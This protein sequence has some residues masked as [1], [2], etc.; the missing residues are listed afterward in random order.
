MGG[1]GSMVGFWGIREGG[2]TKDEICEE[3]EG[4]EM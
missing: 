3:R 4:K 1:N 2:E